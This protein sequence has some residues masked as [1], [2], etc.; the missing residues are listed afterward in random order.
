MAS[1]RRTQGIEGACGEPLTADVVDDDLIRCYI[2]ILAFL[3]YRGSA[4]R[5]SHLKT[6]PLTVVAPPHR[7][8]GV[9][10]CPP[11]PGSF[12]IVPRRVPSALNRSMLPSLRW[13]P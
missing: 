3:T 10:A 4:A 6:E 13:M 1:G 5:R 2:E 8:P 12:R 9:V 7:F 11:P